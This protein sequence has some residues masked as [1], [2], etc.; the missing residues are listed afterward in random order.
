MNAPVFVSGSTGGLS[1]AWAYCN[2]FHAMI[3]IY[4]NV[5]ILT[6]TKFIFY[7]DLQ[8]LS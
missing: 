7:M 2:K 8:C 1:A 4:Y 6:R 5:T 3:S